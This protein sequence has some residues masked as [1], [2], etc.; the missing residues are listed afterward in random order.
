M[1]NEVHLCFLKLSGLTL[2]KN[3]ST[4]KNMVKNILLTQVNK[5]S[6]KDTKEGAR[7]YSSN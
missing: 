1:T 5:V 7:R 2:C 4:Y 3:V 6:F